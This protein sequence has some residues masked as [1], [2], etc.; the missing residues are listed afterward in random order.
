M[1]PSIAHKST[2]VVVA[3]GDTA[4]LHCVPEGR[5]RPLLSWQRDGVLLERDGTHSILSNG[6]LVMYGSSER[7]AGVYVCRV[8]SEAGSV[9]TSV[10]LQ[11]YGTSS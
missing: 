5:P 7:E 9:H 3:T 8:E 6:T 4:A 2:L 10:L 11:V 1:A